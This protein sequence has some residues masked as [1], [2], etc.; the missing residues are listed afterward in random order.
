MSA[1]PVW[2][3]ILVI[4]ETESRVTQLRRIADAVS[5]V[6]GGGWETAASFRFATLGD[7]TGARGPLGEI[8][9]ALGHEGWVDLLPEAAPTA[10]ASDR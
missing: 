10:A 8:W 7:V 3:L 4:A 6:P 5:A 2:P 1:F 9:Q